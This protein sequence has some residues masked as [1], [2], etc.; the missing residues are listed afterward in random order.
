MDDDLALFLACLAELVE[1]SP[2]DTTEHADLD[3][4][5]AAAQELATPTPTPEPTPE[6]DP[7]P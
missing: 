4:L 5:A 6:P 2:E 3:L 1:E 7:A